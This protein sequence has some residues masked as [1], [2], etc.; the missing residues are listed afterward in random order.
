MLMIVFPITIMWILGNVFAG[1]FSSEGMKIENAQVAYSINASSTLESGFNQFAKSISKMDIEMIEVDDKDNAIQKVE[2]GVYTCYLE[3]NED[4]NELIIMKND[5]INN[6]ANLIESMLSTFVQRYNLINQIIKINPQALNEISKNDSED[7]HSKINLISIDENKTPRAIDYYGITMI[8]LIIM[9][10]INVSSNS[11]WGERTRKT[12][13]RIMSTPVKRSEIFIGKIIG[14]LILI[15]AQMSL[16][17][18]FSILVLGVNYGND[19]LTVVLILLSQIVM[20]VSIGV[21]TA[22]LSSNINAMSGVIDFAI[23]VII[24][25]GGGYCPL[26]QIGSK[27]V[28]MM[29]NC[30]PIKWINDS[31]FNVIYLSNYRYVGIAVSICLGVAAVFLLLSVSK[32]NK[33]GEL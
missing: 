3:I 6:V 27:F 4:N 12:S 20:C 28:N 5:N 7:T 22:M 33:M 21:G 1:Q 18:L 13:S 2:K 29:S 24:F 30:S 16:V 23:P 11:I 26:S 14:N 32:F 19:I 31:I 9:Y 8:S 10:S 15:A 25:F 17:I